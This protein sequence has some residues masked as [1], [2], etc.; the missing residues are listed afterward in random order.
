[1]RGNYGKVG[2]IH[3]ATKGR[4]K[5]LK[6]GLFAHSSLS[7]GSAHLWWQ[8][9]VFP[10]DAGRAPLT[11]EVYLPLL[12][13]KGRSEGASGTCCSSAQN[14]PAAKAT[15]IGQHILPPF[16]VYIILFLGIDSLSGVKEEAIF[17]GFEH[18]QNSI[19]NQRM[20]CV[21]IVKLSFS[22]KKIL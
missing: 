8:V 13:R 10:P 11:R 2:K 16:N 17:K 22:F 18:L 19:L 9:C 12:G 3:G 6:Q 5:L 20:Y 1:M 7:L 14:N 21:A 15:Y 4:E